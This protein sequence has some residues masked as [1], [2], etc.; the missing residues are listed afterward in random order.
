[1]SKE[2]P[3]Q[4]EIYFDPYSVSREGDCWILRD[5]NPCEPLRRMSHAFLVTLQSEADHGLGAALLHD[6]SAQLW[7]AAKRV[8]HARDQF[9]DV[10]ALSLAQGNEGRRNA[11]ASQSL[12]DNNKTVLTTI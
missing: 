1:M 6:D 12:M 9:L 8:E 11:I 5:P 10:L 3:G 4:G 7:V 2:T